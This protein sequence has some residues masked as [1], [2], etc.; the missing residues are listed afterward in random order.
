MTGQVVTQRFGQDA[1]ARIAASTPMLMEATEMYPQ[2]W[3]MPNLIPFYPPPSTTD[4]TPRFILDADGNRIWVNFPSRLDLTF[5]QGDDVVVPLTLQDPMMDTD[6]PSTW[7]WHAQIRVLHYYKST[8]VNDF[9]VDADYTAPV[10]PETTGTTLVQLFLPRERNIY[11]GT[12]QWELY[13]VSPFDYSNFA[14]PDDWPDGET[15][16]PADTLKTWLWGQCVIKPRTS[17]TDVLPTISGGGPVWPDI[18]G[19]WTSPFV[20]GPNGRVP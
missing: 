3:T 19:Y 7:E 8:F 6:D 15:W 2:E 12:Y 17:T 1:P 4:D 13:S 11:W 14:Q 5:Y 9:I 16:P 20:V 10:A 18:P